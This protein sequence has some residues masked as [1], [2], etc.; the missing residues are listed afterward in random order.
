MANVTLTT[1]RARVRE[2]ADMVGSSFVADS[3]TSLDAFI[4]AAADELYDLLILKFEDYAQTSSAFVTVAS[5]GTVALPAAF[6]KLDGI[7]LVMGGASYGLEKFT[8]R[9]RNRLQAVNGCP[10]DLPSY[11]LEGNN[12]RLRPTPMAVYSGTIWY[13]PTR[14]LLSDGAHVLD[15]VNGW[16]EYVAIA[17]A[18][19]CLLKEES[20][21]SGLMA[22]LAM[23]KQRIEE[24][25]KDRDQA[26]SSR[27]VDVD[28][29]NDW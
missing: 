23:E 24:A 9:E 5:V 18:I 20:D 8:F 22:L 15:G 27:I 25:S 11:R 21:V 17:A 28:G 12:I 14:T 7:D 6:Y 1:L 2:L 3:A 16:E 26:T 4:N 19:R 13:R 29:L 10:Q